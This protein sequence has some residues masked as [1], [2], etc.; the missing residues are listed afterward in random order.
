MPTATL[1]E[2]VRER[3][4]DALRQWLAETSTLDVADELA[5][6][7]PA[8]KAV[9]FR[10]LDRDRALAVFEA[11]DPAHQQQVLEG[12]RDETVRSLVEDMD[13]DDRARLLDELPAKV[14]RRLLNGLSPAERAMTA[15]LLGYPEDSAGRIMSPEFVN[16]RASMTVADAFAKVRRLAPQAETIYTLP[17][18]DDQRRLMGVVSLRDLVVNPLDARVADL[19]ATDVLAAH[20][21]DD[22]EEAA[23]LIAEA[24]LLDLPV[25]DSEDRL[26][27][28]IT[29]DDAVEVLEEEASEDQVRLGASE[30]LDRPYLDMGVWRLARKRAVWLLV[31]VVAATL[32]VNVLQAFEGTLESVVTLALFIPLLIGAGGNSGSQAATTVIR[33]MAIGE[34]RFADLPRIIW[35]EA[36]VGLLLGLM[37]AAAGFV[38]VAVVFGTDIA[39]VVALTL[40]T[41][42]AWATFAGSMLPLLARR[43]GIDPAVVSAPMI[44][45]LVDASGLVIYLLIARAI[46]GL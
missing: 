41:I 36:R 9:P 23:R 30:P 46:L 4:V 2:L 26:V 43:I 13:P 40:V 35:R 34:V 5:R 7:E 20:V 31:L 28:V 19:M 16:L 8:E 29:V 44:T 21:D 39:V 27:G 12:L 24:D 6:L 3:D 22:Q 10:L 25:L 42:C 32:T 33:A 37:L 14:A 38:P 17:V 18:T 15:V 45:T 1:D 11:L